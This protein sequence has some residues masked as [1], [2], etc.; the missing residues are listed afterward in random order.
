MIS[1]LLQFFTIAVGKASSSSPI[2][3]FTSMQEENKNVDNKTNRIFFIKLC[4]F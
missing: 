2:I 4:F 1:L 3:M